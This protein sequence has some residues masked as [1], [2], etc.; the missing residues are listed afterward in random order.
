MSVCSEEKNQRRC[1]SLFP[2]LVLNS[3]ARVILLSWPPKGLELQ[4]KVSAYDLLRCHKIHQYAVIFSEYFYLECFPLI[5]KDKSPDCECMKILIDPLPSDLKNLQQHETVIPGELPLV[6]ELTSTLREWAVIWRKLYV[7]RTLLSRLECSGTVLAHCNL[8]LPSSSN[9]ASAS[10]VAR[11]TVETMFHHFGQAGLEL[12]TSSD[13]SVLASLIDQSGLELLTSSDTPALASQSVGIIGMSHCPLTTKT[14]YSEIASLLG[15][16]VI[17][18]DWVLPL[19]V[20]SSL[21]WLTRNSYGKYIFSHYDTSFGQ[22]GWVFLVENR[23]YHIGQAGLE[24]LTSGDLPI[25]ASQSAAIQETCTTAQVGLQWRNLSSLQPLPPG[26]KDRVSFCHPGGRTVVQSQF[27]AASN[28]Q[29][30]AIFHLSPLSSW[31]HRHASPHPANFLFFIETESCHFVETESLAQAGLNLLGSSSP[32]TPASQSAK[33]MEFALVTQAG[34]QCCDLSS[35]QPLPP[36]SKRF[37][38]LSLLSNWD[39]RCPPPHPD[40]F[41]IFS[42]DGVSPGWSGWSQTPDLSTGTIGMSHHAWPDHVLLNNKLTL[43]RQLQQMTYSLIEWRS[44]I[45]SGTLPKDELAELKKKVTAKIDHGNRMFTPHKRQ[46]MPTFPFQLLKTGSYFLTKAGV[47]WCNLGLLQPQLPGLKQSS[48]FSPTRNWDYRHMSPHLVNFCILAETGFPH[49]AQAGLELLVSSDPPSSA[50]Q[51]VGITDM[52]HGA[53]PKEVFIQHRMLG[54]DLVVRDDNGNILDPDETSTI[55]LFKA[56]EVASKRIEEKIQ[57]EKA[58]SR[59]TQAGVQRHDLS[60]LQPPPPGFKQFS[61][62]SLPSSWDYRCP[63]PHLANFYIFSRDG[64]SPCWSGWSGT[65]DLKWSTCL[66]L[67]KCWDN[68]HDPLYPD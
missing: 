29:A 31:D 37:S 52:S 48:H 36:G 32:P 41:C 2:R 35:L 53:W 16:F 51:S 68:R 50:S 34:V 59:Y 64:V 17:K 57:E 12:L 3:W 39:Y 63:P 6:Q 67:P 61:C 66:G 11:I 65:A 4:Y 44:Q 1:L 20:G 33:I 45:L 21:L 43:F 22:K 25:L 38:C 13:P 30:Q 7:S 23:F 15:A 14:V 54:L 40:N 62:L 24:L 8:H 18:H 9:S 60:S 56:H 26:F 55:A 10:Q 19:L 46:N 27:T 28:S 5:R 58:E 49:V 47:Q 42:R